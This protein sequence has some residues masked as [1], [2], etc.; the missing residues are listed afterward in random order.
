MT[1]Q[2]DELSFLNGAN[3]VF[4]EDLLA[5]FQKDPASV[6]P[7]WARYFTAIGDN[8]AAPTGPSWQRP[9]WPIVKNGLE[10]D[11]KPAAPKAKA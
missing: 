2:F 3:S 9:D 4:I 10:D 6:D 1:T 7:S 5:R 11:E 8:L